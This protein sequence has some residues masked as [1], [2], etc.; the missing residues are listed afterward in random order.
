ML[1]TRP[2]EWGPLHR[3][4]ARPIKGE[5]KTHDRH[6]RAQHRHRYTSTKVEVSCSGASSGLST[7]RQRRVN[8]L[9]DPFVRARAAVEGLKTARHLTAAVCS[10]GWV[11]L[12]YTSTLQESCAA[13]RKHHQ[14]Q[15]SA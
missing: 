5:N 6:E 8:M 3:T 15:R 13:D 2:L 10:Q 12:W 11:F 14:P 4:N 1:F 7:L 9:L